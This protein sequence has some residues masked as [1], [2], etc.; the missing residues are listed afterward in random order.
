MAE[1]AASSASPGTKR[2]ADPSAKEEVPS[3]KKTFIERSAGAFKSILPP[4]PPGDTSA[5][6]DEEQSQEAAEIAAE[7]SQQGIVVQ[8]IK[9]LNGPSE[10]EATEDAAAFQSRRAEFLSKVVD[11]A[12]A[13]RRAREEEAE[14]EDSSFN[15]NIRPQDED[16]INTREFFVKELKAPTKTPMEIFE[17]DF[18][19]VQILYLMP[20][21]SDAGMILKVQQEQTKKYKEALGPTGR[22]R[23]IPDNLATKLTML[24]FGLP[25]EPATLYNITIS[26]EDGDRTCPPDD[27]LEPPP[28]QRIMYAEK[29]LQFL[30]KYSEGRS[31]GYPM[32]RSESQSANYHET[33]H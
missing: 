23:G 13:V 19:K 2:P 18:T 32:L 31:H 22:F 30:D 10:K 4:S 1:S 21:A 7:K 29:P 12:A 5:S 26:S 33:C 9:E 24:H 14:F 28:V 25:I 3:H 27:P 20:R 8:A 17:K 15:M 16:W 6:A 11:Q